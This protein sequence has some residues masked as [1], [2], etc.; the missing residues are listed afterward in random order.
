LL[1]Q[2]RLWSFQGRD[3]K[4]ERFLAKNQLK[5]NKIENWSSGE[6]SKIGHRFRK[7]RG[8]KNLRYQKMSITKNML[9]NLYSS[10]Q[11][12]SERFG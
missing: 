4:L 3:T 9:L 1:W 2:Y 6:L 7:I 10:M 12:K 11:K 5:L 8:F